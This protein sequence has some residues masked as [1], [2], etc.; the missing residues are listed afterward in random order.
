MQDSSSILRLK[1]FM[2]ISD[3]P[4]MGFSCRKQINP[5]AQF[6]SFSS[7][8][9]TG[10]CWT[11]WSIFL[12]FIFVIKSDLVFYVYLV[13]DN[14]LLIKMVCLLDWCCLLIVC[15]VGVWLVMYGFSSPAL[16]IGLW[17]LGPDCPSRG[18]DL[19][20][21][22]GTFLFICLFMELCAGFAYCM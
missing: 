4:L 14:V 2:G 10:Q 20:G 8:L 12:R 1:T 22:G 16:M 17:F 15:Y 11:Y 19:V 5:K 13:F 18:L 6:S 7:N 21:V 3:D 9:E